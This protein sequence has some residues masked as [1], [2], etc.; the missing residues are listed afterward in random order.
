M[1]YAEKVTMVD[2]WL[3]YL[4]DQVKRM[5]IEQSTL[6][7]MVSD[8][9]Q[10]FG[11]GKHG[12]GIMRKCRPWPYE[13][14]AHA[15]MIMRGP[16]LPAG[17][18]IKGFTQSC[19]V[20]PTLLDWLGLP[21]HPEMTGKSLMPLARGDVDKL[22]D[23]AIA[24]YHGYSASIITEDWSFIHWLRADEKT[25]H[26]SRAEMFG[27]GTAKTSGHIPK[28]AAKGFVSS[29]E[30][31]QRRVKEMAATLD[32]EEQWTC[33][34][35]SFAELPERDMLFDRK[36]DPYQLNNIAPKDPQKAKE[37]YQQLREFMAELR[38]T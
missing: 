21:E 25:I 28:S 3:G 20:A 38:T 37:L 36:E 32:D 31:L 14:L 34:P 33:T 26:E 16:G 6:F 12:H 9:G 2:N 8:H 27:R 30:D 10:P 19:D 17:K 1:L 15:P 29:S 22:R 35:G 5:G 18:R 4:M 23:F 11:E 13:E 24:G 7:L